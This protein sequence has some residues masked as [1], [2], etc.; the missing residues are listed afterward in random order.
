[1]SERRTLARDRS[2][3]QETVGALYRRVRDRFR[4]SRLTTPDLDARRLVCHATGLST[5]GLVADPDRQLDA[6]DG[7][8][9]DDLVVRR[10]AGESVARLTGERDFW[11]RPFEITAETLEPRP[12][13]ETLIEV[14]LSRVGAELAPHATVLDIGTGS[15]ILATTL[16]AECSRMTALAIDISPDAIAVARRNA[17][18]H[19][20]GGRC[21]FACMSYFDAL[22]GR[23]DLI[24]SNPPYIPTADIETLAP[25]VAGHDPRIALD[26]GADGHTA[27]RRIFSQAHSHLN[28]GGLLLVEIGFD[29]AGTVSDLARTNGFAVRST[30][31]DLEGR[32]RAVLALL[33]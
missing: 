10:L 17:D 5:A 20:V 11:G 18:R 16:L 28:P 7:I 1:M 15:G 31:K 14:V 12:D 21:R 8:R 30:V 19:G 13:T 29:Q 32:D 24:V 9:A 6:E 4:Q 27:F 33:P 23:F 3:R 22:S 25:E 26:G 2:D